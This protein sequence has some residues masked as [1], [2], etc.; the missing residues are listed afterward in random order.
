MGSERFLAFTYTDASAGPSAKGAKVAGDQPT[1]AEVEEAV[2]SPGVTL[3]MAGVSSVPLEEGWITY[4]RLPA[5]PP[6]MAHFAGAAKPAPGAASKTPWRD[7]PR[8][9][10][11]FHQSQPDDIEAN[12]VLLKQK[13]IEKMWVRITAPV[14]A[15]AVDI[16]FMAELL[17]Q[18]HHVPEFKPG[19]KVFVRPSKSHPPLLQVPRVAVDNLREWTTVCEGCGF[20]LLFIPVADLAKMQFPNAPAGSVPVRFTTRCIMCQQTMHVAERPK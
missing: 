1:P 16:G 10:G 18:S 12:F 6:W 15:S 7:D 13:T 5:E 8:L 2:Q 20:D 4:L 14:R 19:A 17:N 11:H 3:R 9:A